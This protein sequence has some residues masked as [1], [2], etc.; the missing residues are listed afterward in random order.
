MAKIALFFLLDRT[1]LPDN[2]GMKL[3]VEG[4][5][6]F[7]DSVMRDISLTKLAYTESTAY[8]LRFFKKPFAKDVLVIV[9]DLEYH[10]GGKIVESCCKQAEE[11]LKYKSDKL[12]YHEEYLYRAMWL[13]RGVQKHEFETLVRSF[14]GKSDVDISKLSRL[15]SRGSWIMDHPDGY[16]FGTKNENDFLRSV[17]L[18][19]LAM[20]FHQSLSDAINRLSLA[21]STQG[22]QLPSMLKDVARFSG[23]YYF[24]NPVKTGARADNR[25]YDHLAKRF[26]FAEMEQML[27]AK[28]SNATSL[29]N[30][31]HS[32]SSQ[33]PIPHHS[34][35]M[36]A[37]VRYPVE[38]R[39]ESGQSSGLGR[40]L[41]IL[42]LLLALAGGAM[43]LLGSEDPVQLL[44]QL[45]GHAPA[46]PE[47]SSQ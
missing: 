41:L 7:Y 2:F 8:C 37:D 14:S 32:E 21:M 34:D 26:H 43:V 24:R 9:K 3:S 1:S 39:R 19:S 40:W 23:S 38:P 16:I 11:I 25:E 33:T 20:S 28:V 29:I 30:L 18:Y 15:D 5:A 36:A 22:D 46:A 45:M 4:T 27:A 42:L 47:P 44:Q 10:T 17:V 31:R 6:P 13:P 35:S 12:F